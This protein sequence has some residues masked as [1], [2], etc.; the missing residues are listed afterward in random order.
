[1]SPLESELESALLRLYQQWKEIKYNAICFKRMITACDPIYKG[2]TGT[3]KHLLGK[4]STQKSGFEKLRTAGKL[5]WTVEALISED[6]RFQG[7]FEP[8]EVE[9]ARERYRAA[10]SKGRDWSSET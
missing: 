6:N 3:V 5:G 4:K 10:S 1:M 7:L 2:P 9:R 8:W